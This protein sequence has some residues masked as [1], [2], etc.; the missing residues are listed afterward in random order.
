MLSL[1]VTVPTK[2]KTLREK[3]H[4]C[5][6][7]KIIKDSFSTIYGEINVYRIYH[8]SKKSYFTPEKLS[9]ALSEKLY[10]SSAPIY[11]EYLKKLVLLQLIE[12]LK[13]NSGKTVYLSKEFLNTPLLGEICRYSQKVYI[14][15]EL[16]PNQADSIFRKYGT[17]PIYTSA[18]IAADFCP[19]KK[20]AFLLSL[21]EEV[22]DICPDEFFPLLFASLVYKENSVMIT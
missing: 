4:L 2:R 6:K 18:P 17:L 15:G 21:P 13:V 22:K 7:E 11:E 10:T 8:F 12:K 14:M 16:L 9:Q 19:D 5:P 20:D 1:A 3:L